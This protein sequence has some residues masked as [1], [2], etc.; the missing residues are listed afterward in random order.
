MKRLHSVA[1]LIASAHALGRVCEVIGT[2]IVTA[3]AAP[4]NGIVLFTV[5]GCPQSEAY[6][7]DLLSRDWQ[8]TTSAADLMPD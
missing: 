6:V 8:D 1:E 5:D 2:R 3:V 4:N 7:N